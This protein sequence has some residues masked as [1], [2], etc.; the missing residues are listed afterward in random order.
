VRPLRLLL[1]PVSAAL[2][3]LA[4]RAYYGWS[5]PRDW[6][7]DLVTGWILVACGLIGWS[8]RPESRSGTLTA[9]TG[10]AWFAGNFAGWAL[11]LHRG[12]LVHLALSYPRGQLRGRIERAAVAVVYAAAIV[13]P[14]WQSET[15]T[16]VLATFLVMVAG[17]GYLLA[18]GPERRARLAALRASTFL[19]AVLVG[20]A[21]A[22]LVEPTQSAKGATLLAYETAL[23]VLGV[24]LLA[25]LIRA[26]AESAEVTD[27]VVELA[28]T[29]SGTLRDALARAL[30]DPALRVGYWRPESGRYVDAAGQ[31]LELSA[32][33][34]DRSVTRIDREGQ[35]VAVLVHDPA[36]LDDPALIG[37]VA[38]AARLS[39]SNARL[40]ADVQAQVAELQA[41]RRRLVQ[42]ADEERRR[43][44]QR[45][46]EGAAR[47][48]AALAPVLERARELASSN[49]IVSV[50]RAGG[51]LGR[52]VAELGE[53]AGGLHPRELTERG[54]AG[55]LASLVERSA[56]RAELAVPAERL[57]E[58]VEATVYFV[59]S[60]AL[61]NVA[62]YASA[63]RVDV[64]VTRGDGLVRVEVVD[65][66]VGGAD[67]A[68]G[69]GLR[70][71]ANRVEAIGGAL[72][73][74]SPPGEGTRLV[75]EI[76][77]G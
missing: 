20:D 70:G 14:V 36:V 17:R 61:A 29:R 22:R 8:R 53:L 31:P 7:P 57:P 65:D 73:I 77:L 55:A 13:T 48:L 9:A 47:R 44:E 25:G 12:P 59:C 46:H 75:A 37:A 30:G 63:S 49:T 32:R 40:R 27:L 41:S 76:P 15:G 50:E 39:A 69:T 43:L 16:I 38:A 28:E 54:L 45:L 26:P 4:E 74:D 24:G 71:L 23:C 2:G 66:G 1:W 51:Q 72:Q 6:V 56:V 42:V 10:L 5:D 11:Y 67:P 21:I 60:E 68:R 34:G 33:D 19:A 3:I 35:P 62:K 52:T 18:I 58:D 64:L